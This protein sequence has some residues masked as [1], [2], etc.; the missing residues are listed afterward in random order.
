MKRSLLRQQKISDSDDLY[1]YFLWMICIILFYTKYIY[2]GGYAYVI[3]V[4]FANS[5]SPVHLS[6]DFIT[7]SLT[8]GEAKVPNANA[9]NLYDIIWYIYMI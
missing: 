1:D 2:C 7:G 4:S 3:F 9:Y 8:G 5:K 6:V